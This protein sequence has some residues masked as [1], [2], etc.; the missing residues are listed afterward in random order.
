MTLVEAVRR[1]RTTRTRLGIAGV[2]TPEDADRA[3]GDAG[4]ERWPDEPMPGRLYGVYHR[5]VL[6]VRSGLFPGT[7]LFVLAH[8]LGHAAMGHDGGTYRARVAGGG[9]E[10][11][12]AEAEASVWA[13]VFLLGEPAR[14][15]E[16]LDA[17]LH[18][19]F[20]AGLPLGFLFGCAS[21]FGA[22]LAAA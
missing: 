5:G 17:Q 6:R 19:G 7:R 8:E 4:V 10:D 16:G 14:T 21:L 3:L 20:D 22:A 9:P 2:A 15:H 1:A 12:E 11:S 13:Y 18:A